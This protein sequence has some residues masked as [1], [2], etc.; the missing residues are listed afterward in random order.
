MRYTTVISTIAAAV[1]ALTSMSVDAGQGHGGAGQG[2]GAN[3]RTQQ[4]DTDR[5]MDRDRDRLHQKDSSNLR[6]RDIYGSDLMS[7][8]ELDK[9]REQLVKAETNRERE[10]FQIRHEEKMKQRAAQQGKDLVPP[11]QG[12]IYGG[13]RMTAKERNAYREQLR[14]A[15]SEKEKQQLQAQHQEKMDQRAKAAEVDK[16]EAE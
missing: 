11:G 9:Y 5:D 8:Q 13:E 4:M 15:G 16:E 14:L 1:L 7:K 3:D 10:Q 6:D 2:G 12:P